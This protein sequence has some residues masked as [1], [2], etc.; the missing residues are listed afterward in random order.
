MFNFSNKRVERRLTVIDDDNDKIDTINNSN[1]NDVN[2]NYL[3]FR[4]RS[5]FLS[6]INCSRNN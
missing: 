6:T 3:I 1:T 4:E 2:N 5:R